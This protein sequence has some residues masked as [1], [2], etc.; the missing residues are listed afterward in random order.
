[1]QA[2]ELARSALEAPLTGRFGLSRAELIADGI[3]HA[4]G[5]V[6]AISAGSIL[7]AFAVFHT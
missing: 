2:G 6:L 1:M 4:I 7:L 3:V 5:I